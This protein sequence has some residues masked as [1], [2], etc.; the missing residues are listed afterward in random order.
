MRASTKHFGALAAPRL[1]NVSTDFDKKISHMQRSTGT[2]KPID[3]VGAETGLDTMA[4]DPIQ[5]LKRL[6]TPFQR[7]LFSL[8]LACGSVFL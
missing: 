6:P 4:E 2:T 5:G 3:G 8:W 1:S 7:G